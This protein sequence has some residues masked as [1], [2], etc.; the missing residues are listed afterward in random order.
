MAFIYQFTLKL[1]E[2]EEQNAS[3]PANAV[4]QNPHT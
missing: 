4:P 2:G 3:H 1:D